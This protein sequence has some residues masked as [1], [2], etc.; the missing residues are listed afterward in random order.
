MIRSDKPQLTWAPCVLLV[1][2]QICVPV[3]ANAA[4]PHLT[5]QAAKLFQQAKDTGHFYAAAAK[6][7]PDIRPTSEGKSFV[8]IWKASKSPTRWIVSLHGAG[9][10][11]KGF[12]TDDLAIWQPHLK[13]RDVGLICLQWWLGNGNGPDAFYAPREIYRETDSILK[14]LG[15][16][17]GAVMLEGFSRG[18]ANTY[19]IAALDTGRGKRYF[20]L[21][22][23]SSGGMSPNYPP[24]RGIANG[25]YGE[26]PLNGTRWITVAGGRDP[27][28]DR[29]GIPGMQRTAKWLREQ[30]AVVVE[31]IEDQDFGHG[32]LHRN[33]KNTRRVLDLFLK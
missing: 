1:Q 10:P 27:Q 17:P 2:M 31:T 20:S 4:E 28:P 5:G 19:A 26:R 18:A 30:G 16:K 22:V 32:A 12:A 14:Q 29:D 21:F 23:A 24:N 33:P 6:L 7:N 13:D 3:F 25:D 8:V 11:A 9:F 15:V